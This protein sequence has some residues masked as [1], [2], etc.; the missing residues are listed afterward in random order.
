MAANASQPVVAGF[1]PFNIS[2]HYVI[3]YSN[4]LSLQRNICEYVK[5]FTFNKRKYQPQHKYKS[6]RFLVLSGFFFVARTVGVC[7]LF[8]PLGQ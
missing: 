3:K 6:N 7:Y 5:P 8:S 1:V 2:Q 4:P